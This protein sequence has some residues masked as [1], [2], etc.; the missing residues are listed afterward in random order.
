MSINFNLNGKTIYVFPFLAIINLALFIIQ[1]QELLKLEEPEEILA[2]A[3]YK[4]NLFRMYRNCL[5]N[6]TTFILILQIFVTSRKYKLYAVAKDNLLELK[7]KQ[8][9]K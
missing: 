7:S 3:I 4:E 8:K 5:L 2:K 9:S 6:A 1:Y